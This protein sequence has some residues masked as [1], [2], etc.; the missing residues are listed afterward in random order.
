[1]EQQYMKIAEVINVTAMSKATIYRL[2][3]TGDFPAPT[4]LGHRLVRW[5]IAKI[6]AWMDVKE[7][8][9]H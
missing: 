5:H 7:K 2:M 3:K 1:M 9:Y 6:K 4:K 8:T